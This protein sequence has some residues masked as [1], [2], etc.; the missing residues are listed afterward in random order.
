MSCR[1]NKASIRRGIRWCA[2][3]RPA[4]IDPATTSNLSAWFTPNGLPASGSIDTWTT[5]TVVTAD[6]STSF[7]RIRTATTDAGSYPAALDPIVGTTGGSTSYM[8]LRGNRA[9]VSGDASGAVNAT[10]LNGSHYALLMILRGVAGGSDRY[11]HEDSITDNFVLFDV[12]DN[13]PGSSNVSLPA[14]LNDDQWQG[15]LLVRTGTAEPNVVY[16]TFNEPAFALLGS[17]E[18]FESRFGLGFN[19][20]TGALFGDVDFAYFGIWRLQNAGVGRSFRED[21]APGIISWAEDTV[22]VLNG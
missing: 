5:D 21:T 10:L 15:L 8:D 12:W 20:D 3:S 6:F 14:P 18:L 9:A 7:D 1:R 2:A 22:N 13:G 16:Q 17:S 11:F 4:P 19:S